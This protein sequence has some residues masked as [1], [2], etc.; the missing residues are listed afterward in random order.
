L[1]QM[2][3][4]LM[5]W[6]N[7]WILESS[8]VQL[9]SL[10]SRITLVSLVQLTNHT[11]IWSQRNANNALWTTLLTQRLTNALQVSQQPQT[12]KLTL[13]D[14]WWMKIKNLKIGTVM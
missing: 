8:N 11:S 7:I 12:L 3:R 4:Q 1:S 13:Q 5:L 10:S 14:W 6:K 9:I 2:E